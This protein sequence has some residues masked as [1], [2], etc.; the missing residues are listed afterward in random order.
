MKTS[1]ELI[2]VPVMSCL[3]TYTCM[4][5]P[6]QSCVDVTE[7][8]AVPERRVRYVRTFH[9]D[10]A[11][12]VLTEP[13]WKLGDISESTVFLESR[14]VVVLAKDL[15]EANVFLLLRVHTPPSLELRSFLPFFS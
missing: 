8:L 7:C 6:G 14:N 2:A 4:C 10:Q 12:L 5:V 13:A 3:S 15:S 9:R 11:I 1:L